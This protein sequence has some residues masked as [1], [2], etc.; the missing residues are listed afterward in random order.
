LFLSHPLFSP[1]LPCVSY[2]Y[3]PRSR[4]PEPSGI[5]DGKTSTHVQEKACYFRRKT[6]T[7][8]MQKIAK[9]LTC[10]T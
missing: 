7:K 8:N 9:L 10:L 6:W 5:S 2:F 4:T 3:C 1:K